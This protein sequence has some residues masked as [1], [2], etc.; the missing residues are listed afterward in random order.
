[1]RLRTV[2]LVAALALAALT[3]EPVHATSRQQPSAPASAQVTAHVTAQGGPRLVGARLGTGATPDLDIVNPSAVFAPDTPQLVCVWSV[4][5]IPSGGTTIKGVWVAE[6]T[7]GAAPPNYVIGETPYELAGP[8]PMAGRFDLSK[9]TRGWPP[10]KYRLELHLAGRLAH[11]VAFRIMTAAEA[12]VYDAQ[13]APLLKRADELEKAGDY[14]QAAALTGQALGVAEKNLGA[15]HPDTAALVNNLALLLKEAGDY[16]RSEELYRRAVALGEKLGG[17]EQPAFAVAL[18][19]LAELERLKGDYPRAESLL[20]RALPV[21]EKALGNE[22]PF[23]A[24]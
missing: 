2:A 3:A 6:D 5:D 21:V 12:E 22:H 10:G 9:P 1:M 13:L 15:E 19:N 18:S 14:K 24:I 16:A 8:Q 4:A 23:V 7:G 17:A 20:A 11:T